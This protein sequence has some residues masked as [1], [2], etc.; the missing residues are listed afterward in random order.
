MCPRP[1]TAMV[2]QSKHISL[3]QL[4]ITGRKAQ[5]S[6][7]KHSTGK[8]SEGKKTEVSENVF[9]HLLLYSISQ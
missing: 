2:K 3:Q 9:L 4:F 6:H 7:N 5:N 8:Y 1:I